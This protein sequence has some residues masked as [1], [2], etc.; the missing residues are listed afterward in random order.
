ME[1][2]QLFSVST[3][4]IYLIETRVQKSRFDWKKLS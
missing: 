1:V 2:R 3:I 4:F